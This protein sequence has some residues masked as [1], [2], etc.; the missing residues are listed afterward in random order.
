MKEERK[1]QVGCP[2]CGRRLRTDETNSTPEE[3]PIII[4]PRITPNPELIYKRVLEIGSECITCGISFNQLYHRLK[5]HENFEFDENGCLERC[6]RQWFWH[7]FF[8][9]EAHCPDVNDVKEIDNHLDCGFILKAESCMKLLTFKESEQNE[10]AALANER[11]TDKALKI[12]KYSNFIAIL[13]FIISIL[14]FGYT[15]Y[16]DNYTE[17]NQDKYLKELISVQKSLND[18]L[19][20]LLLKRND[21]LNNGSKLKN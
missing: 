10:R 11:K 9:E 13:G 8:H 19:K 17:C 18:S 12:A 21:T 14:G 3:Q 15:Y 16:K 1:K 20:S 4:N 2:D 5:Y 7:S 6:L